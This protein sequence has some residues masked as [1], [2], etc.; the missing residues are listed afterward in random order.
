MAI[1]Y[2]ITGPDGSG[3]TTYL[4]ELELYFSNKGI[5]SEYIWLRSPKIFSKPL[6]AYCRL[7]GLTKCTIINGIKY[8]RHEFYRSKYVSKLFPWLQL[9]DQKIK[10]CLVNKAFKSSPVIL[11]DR[12]SLDTLADLMVDTKN[13]DLHKTYVGRSF[14]N[15][16]PQ[17][18]NIIVLSVRE[19]FIR[20][21]KLDTRFDQT[22][23][24]RIKAYRVLSDELNLKVV[25]NN[26]DYKIVKKEIFALLSLSE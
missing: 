3:K 15:S 17:G 13:F 6:M 5:V 2:Y 24:D 20:D 12:F 22:I 16:I 21:R 11:L 19:E 7:V 10:I 14:I 1:I 23:A 26:K 4:K 25:D 8:G 18:T 9:I